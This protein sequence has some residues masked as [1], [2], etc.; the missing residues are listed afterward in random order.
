[1]TCAIDMAVATAGL[2]SKCAA[3]ACS[4]PFRQRR[5]AA[6]RSGST[7]VANVSPFPKLMH[8]ASRCLCAFI[9]SSLFFFSLWP[10]CHNLTLLQACCCPPTCTTVL[11]LQ[12]S[13]YTTP[14]F[15][16]HI[17]D[18]LVTRNYSVTLIAQA[19]CPPTCS[20][21]ALHLLTC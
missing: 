20:T 12:L 19:L 17:S 4:A 9:F 18:I 16:L 14:T 21:H 10:A 15:L 7:N 13:Y 11:Q 1:M 8:G 2:G 5:C 6:P 3:Q